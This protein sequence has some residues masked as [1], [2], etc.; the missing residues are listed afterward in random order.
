MHLASPWWLLLLV[1]VLLLP[2]QAGLTGR[3]RLAVARLD[4]MQRR[5]TLR[6][7]LAPLTPVLSVVGLALVVLALARP[8]VT[9]RE[10]VVES[11][12]LDIMLSVDTS[13]S[14]KA[15]DFSRGLSPVNR[16]QVRVSTFTTRGGS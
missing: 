9:H 2:L 15:E 4:E 14:M 3:N 16:L 5:F 13:G 8:Q 12:G 6:L 11:E 7:A 1:P 10:V